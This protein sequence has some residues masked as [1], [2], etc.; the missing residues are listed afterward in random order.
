M[1]KI[2]L[3]CLALLCLTN[4]FAQETVNYKEKK[5]YKTWVKMAPKLND[6]FFKTPEAIRIGD[7]VL[8]YQ[9]TTGGWPKNIYMPAELTEQELEDVLASKDEVNEST[10]DNDATSTEIQS[11]ACIWLLILRNTETVRWTVSVIS[12]KHNI[13]MEAGLSSGPVPKVTTHISPTM[14][15]RW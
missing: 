13:P 8:L 4:L 5:P 9:Q 11:P 10:I 1:K 3:C 2:C 6:E 15:T 7:N 12:S 14:T